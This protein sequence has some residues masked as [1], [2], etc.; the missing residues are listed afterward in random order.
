MGKVKK[1]IGKV[2]GTILVLA[3]IL[4]ATFI[5]LKSCMHKHTAKEIITSTV[6]ERNSNKAQFSTDSVYY[7]ISQEVLIADIKDLINHKIPIT[8]Q[9]IVTN[10]KRHITIYQN[11]DERTKLSQYIDSIIAAKKQFNNYK[12]IPK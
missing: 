9:N 4:T 8:E 11:I 6:V 3:V 2:V 5:V 10:Y 1:N 7:T 12:Y